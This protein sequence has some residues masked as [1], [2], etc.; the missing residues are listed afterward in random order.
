MTIWNPTSCT[1]PGPHVYQSALVISSREWLRMNGKF[2][3]GGSG[4][5][6]GVGGLQTFEVD[7][8]GVGIKMDGVLEEDEETPG[9][10]VGVGTNCMQRV[11]I[12]QVQSKNRFSGKV[13]LTA[14]GVGSKIR[15]W[16]NPTRTSEI[17]TFPKE[18]T[19][20]SGLPQD[21]WME[22]IAASSA[23]NDVELKVSYT[24]PTENKTAEDKVKLTVIK[25][26]LDM[27]VDDTD[28]QKEESPGAIVFENWDNDD[29][30][31][32]HTP[33]KT[34]SSVTG[35]NDLVPIYPKFEPTFPWQ[36]FRRQS[37]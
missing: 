18:Y 2:K 30:D 35:E 5:G 26:D 28:E 36:F 3:G 24:T 21:I 6:A 11:T 4:A 14:T 22:G 16:S 12:N 1:G 25:V 17:T 23:T 34:E 37:H 32:A 31:V 33:D 15:L 13:K 19:T 27:D 9:G 8:P 10:Y 20:P 7:V 29:A